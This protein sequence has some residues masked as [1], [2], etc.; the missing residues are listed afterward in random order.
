MRRDVWAV[1]NHKER[2]I[3]LG[4]KKKK[5]Q[6]VFGNTNPDFFFKIKERKIAYTVHDL[7]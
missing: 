4:K 6:P 1:V 2:F 5:L 7:V 3:F